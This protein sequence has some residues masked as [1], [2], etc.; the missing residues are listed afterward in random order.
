MNPQNTGKGMMVA[1]CVLGLVV[2]TLFFGGI[3]EE[4]INPNQ[5]PA[6]RVSGDVVEVDL[7]RNRAGHYVVTGTINDE[8]VDFL[9]DTGATDVV[10]PGELANELGLP[11][12]RTG[13]AMTANGPVTIYATTIDQ[14]SIG[15]IVLREVQASINPA[16]NDIGILLGMSALGQVEFRQE[17]DSLTL[18]QRL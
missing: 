1:A 10:V 3:E 15:D 17:G 5:T 4:R 6:S 14:L 7:E 11:R 8:P 9:L 2:M 13:R 18:R 16:M 12:G